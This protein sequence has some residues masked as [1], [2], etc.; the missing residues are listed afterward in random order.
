MIVNFY[1]YDLIFTGNDKA[2][3]DEFKNSM[4]LEFY[5]Y[6]LGK[7]KHF[8]GIEVKHSLDGIFICQRRYA[9]DVLARFY[10]ENINAVKN[11]IVSGTKLHENEGRARVDET[12]FKQVVWSLMYLTVTKND[13]MYVVS[14]IS[15]FMSSPTM[16]RCIV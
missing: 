11:P 8:L 14:L 16:S 2:M 4:M 12:L 9:G 6:D 3:C 10:M 13:M 5:M 1:M 15:R 7:M